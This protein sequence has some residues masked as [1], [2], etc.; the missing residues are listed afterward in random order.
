MPGG[1]ALDRFGLP[2]L[3][4]EEMSWISVIVPASGGMTVTLIV[5]IMKILGF[6]AARISLQM[7]SHVRCLVK[8]HHLSMHIFH[9]NILL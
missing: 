6:D 4:V 2:I 8:F 1:M 9:D 3:T 5:D 7:D